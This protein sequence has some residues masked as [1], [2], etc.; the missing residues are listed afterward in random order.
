LGD[1]HAAPVAWLMDDFGRKYNS[2]GVV[3]S[4]PSLLPALGCWRPTSAKEAVEWN[5]SVLRYIRRHHISNVILVGYWGI[6]VEGGEDGSPNT[7][8]V[9]EA[10]PTA[11]FADAADVLRRGL[12]RTVQALQ[13]EGCT[14]WIM[15]QIPA[16]G[17]KPAEIALVTMFG[18]SEL[19]E[20]G[21]SLEK[22]ESQQARVNRII[23]TESL[24]DVRILD[25]KPVC[26]TNEGESRISLNGRSF[27]YDTN[28]LSE[29]GT[30]NLLPSLFDPVVRAIVGRESA[31]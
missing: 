10:T 12:Q 5:E 2:K 14:I 6:N 29:F 30:S 26:F 8:I 25:P 20:T 3:A 23:S 27:Y 31:K 1:S 13:K 19:P 9:D 21:E 15:R 16:Q 11:N 7:L 22:Y 24:G 28:H 18:R 4:R 17:Q